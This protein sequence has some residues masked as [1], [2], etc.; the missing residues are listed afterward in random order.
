MHFKKSGQSDYYL[1]SP[2]DKDKTLVRK[3]DSPTEAVEFF[4]SQT[5]KSE[6]AIGKHTGKD[7]QF[8][9]TVATMADGK[10]DYV[11]ILFKK[12]ICVTH[13]LP[14]CLRNLKVTHYDRNY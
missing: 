4:K 5:G 2:G 13:K 9:D 1:V 7:L 10:V 6:L 11:T 12:N 3:F 8:R 14:V